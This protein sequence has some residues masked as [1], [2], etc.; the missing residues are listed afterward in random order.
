VLDAL[1]EVV[2]HAPDAVAGALRSVSNPQQTDPELVR[3]RLVGIEDE[4]EVVAAAVDR[5]LFGPSESEPLTL[6]HAAPCPPA[7]LDGVV[8]RAGIDDND[9]VGPRHRLDTSFDARSLVL[10]DDGDR[11]RRHGQLSFNSRMVVASER[12]LSDQRYFVH[13]S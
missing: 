13:V 2:R 5:K 8:D 6:D 10:R 1:P 9:L 7:E 3:D 11:E 4:N 12:A